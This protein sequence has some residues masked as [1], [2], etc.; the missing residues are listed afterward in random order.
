MSERTVWSSGMYEAI[1]EF[2]VQFSFRPVIE[3]RKTFA[4]SRKAVVAGMGGSGIAAQLL[5][6]LD[7]TLSI[8]AHRDYGLPLFPKRELRERLIILSSYSGNTEEV[9]DA[10]REARRRKLR[11]VAIGVG[12][13]L[14]AAA[15]RARIPYILLPRSGIQPRMALGFSLRAHLAAMGATAALRRTSALRYT[16]RADRYE[17]AGRKLAE[18]L[19]GQVPLIYASE[20]NRGIAYIWKI[21]LNETAKIPAFSNRFPELN[22]NEMTGFDVSAGTERL[23]KPFHALIIHDPADHPRNRRRMAVL[24]TLYRKRGIPVIMIPLAQGDPYRAI[25]GNILLADW[26]AYYL[27]E[28][29]GTD[30]EHVPMVEE[31]KRLI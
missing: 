24:E 15:R 29:Y 22:H 21:K 13:A 5:P 20:Q 3:N 28:Q 9:L 2:P 17:D 8:V 7:P 31:F 19:K 6:R 25:F 4:P 27:A 16:L 14:I 12:G 10:F 11:M 23:A 1:K 30:P 26:T 18:E